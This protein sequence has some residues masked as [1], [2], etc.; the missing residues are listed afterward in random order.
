MTHS[1]VRDF[2]RLADELREHESER[3]RGV[4][5]EAVVQDPARGR[6]W[7]IPEGVTLH[8]GRHRQAELRVRQPDVS[9]KHAALTCSP[10]GLT[11]T[12]LSPR[13]TWLDGRRLE[14]PAVAPA[15]AELRLGAEARLQVIGRIDPRKPAHVERGLLHVPQFGI[16]GGRSRSPPGPRMA[17]TNRANFSHLSS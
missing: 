16:F 10:A 15:G 11:V 7:T 6:V 4:R 8:V 2:R 1:R 17:S 13:G 14:A 12:N 9:R 5:I 3:L